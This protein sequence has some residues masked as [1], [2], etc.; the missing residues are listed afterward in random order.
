MGRTFGADRVENE[1]TMAID[2]PLDKIRDITNEDEKDPLGAFLQVGGMVSPLFGVISAAKGALDAQRRWERIKAAIRGLCDELDRVQDRW[3][4][5]LDMA[6]ESDWFRRAI[7]TL[8]EESERSINDDHARLLARVAAHGC[9]PTGQDAHR[10]EDLATYIH[11]LARLGEDD[12]QMLTL[13]GES[14]RE[15]LTKTPNFHDPN[16][17]SMHYE[18]FCHRAD[19]LKIHNDDRLSSGARLAGF[20]L[21]ILSPIPHTSTGSSQEFYRPSKRGY[22][23]LSLLKAAE[24]PAEKQNS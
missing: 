23:L 18:G 4:K 8:I 11:D 15:A 16:F 2:N 22:Y 10:Q 19:K 7:R 12:I 13:L 3:P 24:L 17:F 1:T 5:E 6:F 21:A 14:Y 9:F 20:G